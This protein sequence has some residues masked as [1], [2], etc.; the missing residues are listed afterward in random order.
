MEVPTYGTCVSRRVSKR[1]FKRVS[2]NFPHASP[3]MWQ[4]ARS[5]VGLVNL[6]NFMSLGTEIEVRGNEYMYAH[7]GS[8][9]EKDIYAGRRRVT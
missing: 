9:V 4:R 6:A 5:Q 7:G 3:D 8:F 2:R 1:V